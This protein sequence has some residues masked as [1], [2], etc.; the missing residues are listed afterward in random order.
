MLFRVLLPLHTI[1][2]MSMIPETFIPNRIE[3]NLWAKVSHQSYEQENLCV[4]ALVPL[5]A[6]ISKV[7]HSTF[8]FWQFLVFHQMNDL[9]KLF[10]TMRKLKFPFF[11]LKTHTCK[12][13]Y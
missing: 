8:L 7:F 1:S 10:P 6:N 13:L 11:E 5:C 12:I 3:Q 2:Q 9:K 4:T